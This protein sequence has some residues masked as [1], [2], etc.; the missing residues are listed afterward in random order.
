MYI[1]KCPINN[2]PCG[3]FNMRHTYA[4]GA[5][6][7]FFLLFIEI[8]IDAKHAIKA[9]VTAHTNQ[10]K[11]IIFIWWR[12]KTQRENRTINYQC[13]SINVRAIPCLYL[14]FISPQR[15]VVSRSTTLLSEVYCKWSR[16]RL[17][18]SSTRHTHCF[19]LRICI[20]RKFSS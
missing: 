7:C 17:S 1:R 13:W 5:L 9:I 2:K 10:I 3:K 4:L 8:G 18:S 6:Q 12:K 15:F 16:S 11:C 14:H 20:L 19:P